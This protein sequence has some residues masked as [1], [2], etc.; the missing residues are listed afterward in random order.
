[1]DFAANYSP[2]TESLLAQGRIA[3]DRFK[4]PAWPHLVS[5][6]SARHRVH[7]H[8]PLLAGWGRGDALDG[9]T[10]APADWR[11]VE[12]LLAA[13]G[14]PFVNLHLS[15][16]AEHYPGVDPADAGPGIASRV[17]ENLIRDVEAVVR[18]FGRERVI[19]EN[20]PDHAICMRAA[21]LPGVIR[22][23]VEVTG[24]GLLLD[25]G[26]ARITAAAQG[27]DARKYAAA[28]PVA[29]LREIHVAGVQRLEGAWVERLLAAGPEGEKTVARFQGRLLDH[30]PLVDEDWSLASW[31]LGRVRAGAW[32]A[33]D[34]VTLEYGGVGPAWEAVTLEDAVAEQVPRLRA[35]VKGPAAAD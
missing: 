23:V 11:R 15:P 24:C 33:P 7:V 17:A 6:V 32:H 5:R 31:A 12:S 30:L 4:C 21:L 34:L 22:Q 27:L 8:F 14:T 28:L 1:M 10:H 19:V 35:L 26:H 9:E 29:C 20:D 18:R 3:L 25:L 2:V 16:D 13:T